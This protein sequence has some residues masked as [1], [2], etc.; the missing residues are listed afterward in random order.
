MPH[1]ANGK[2]LNVGD[3]V[4]LP[5]TVKAVTTSEEY[6]NVTLETEHAM[7]PGEYKTGVTVNAKQVVKP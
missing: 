2:L 5:C 6:C 3:K 4:N 7:Y 1:D